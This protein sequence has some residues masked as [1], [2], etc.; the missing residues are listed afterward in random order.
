MLNLDDSNL[1]RDLCSLSS[2]LGNLT[3]KIIYFSSEG[4]VVG[5]RRGS[6]CISCR[7]RVLSSGQRRFQTGELVVEIRLLVLQLSQ[8]GS[9]QRYIREVP[10]SCHTAL[11]W[12]F[13]W[14]F[15]WFTLVCKC[16]IGLF[17]LLVFGC[18]RRSD[19]GQLSLL[20]VVD[21]LQ[22]GYRGR[23][24][25]SSCQSSIECC[26]SSGLFSDFGVELVCQ[27]GDLCLG[28]FEGSCE[29]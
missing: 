17:N 22:V 21:R 5:L 13:N 27:S 8:L 7:Q 2:L 10:S 29:L 11:N 6:C 25:C 4:I 24:S 12:F 19:S 15:N 3:L 18:D 9:E 1:L 20:I 28:S 26:C 16:S 23:C 14:F